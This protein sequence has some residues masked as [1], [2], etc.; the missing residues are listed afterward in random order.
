MNRKT[1]EKKDSAGLGLMPATECW[2]DE[3]LIPRIDCVY[4][5]HKAADSNPWE[6]DENTD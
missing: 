6:W 2:L 1:K 3:E 5:P 4:I